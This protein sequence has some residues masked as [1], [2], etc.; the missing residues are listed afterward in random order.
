MVNRR[1]DSGTASSIK[2]ESPC[3][4]TDYSSRGTRDV[5]SAFIGGD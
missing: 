3:Q 4:K 2:L 5:S 1:K